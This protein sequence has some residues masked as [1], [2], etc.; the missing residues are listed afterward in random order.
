MSLSSQ[1]FD[2]LGTAGNVTSRITSRETTSLR[3]SPDLLDLEL[4]NR[5]YGTNDD[6]PDTGDKA[7]HAFA[8]KMADFRIY[9]QSVPDQQSATSK[10]RKSP[11]LSSVGPPSLKEKSSAP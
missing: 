9:N 6:K 7:E 10:P 11:L 2:A 5:L 1:L 3:V 4:G 8:G